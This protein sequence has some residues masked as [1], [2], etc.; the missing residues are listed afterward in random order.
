MHCCQ[1][2]PNE[3]QE[4]IDDF[5]NVPLF[6]SQNF[7]VLPSLG[8]LVEGWLLL[9]PKEHFIC[10]G[11]LPIQLAAEMQEMKRFVRSVLL[12][13]YGQVCIFEHGPSKENLSIGCGVDHA[14]L[15]FVPVSLDLA[16]AIT[17]LLPLD[18]TWSEAGLND[19]MTAFEEGEDYLYLERPTGFGRIAKHQLL[20]SQLFR[21]A[22]AIH[23]G[24][25]HQFNWREY[26]Q[27]SNISNT[28]RKIRASSISA[29][30][31]TYTTVLEMEA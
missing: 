11:A 28:I 6:E 4:H 16:S 8:A 7:K 2:C 12:Q 3:K 19:C 26:P 5:W 24:V 1:L 15:H 13:C 17:P 23:A 22:V 14:H 27:I 31:H 10:M 29:M 18:V 30:S 20:T 21:R 25:P 9:V